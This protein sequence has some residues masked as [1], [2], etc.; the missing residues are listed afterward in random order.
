MKQPQFVV[1]DL[2]EEL[3]TFRNGLVDLETIKPMVDV[4]QI[5]QDLLETVLVGCNDW[6]QA[7]HITY[8]NCKKVMDRHV[9]RLYFESRVT[10]WCESLMVADTLRA[11]VNR[12]RMSEGGEFHYQFEKVERDGLVVLSLKWD[13]TARAA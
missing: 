9:D 4:R 3:Q 10:I 5:Q 7:L 1:F 8:D 12:H 2:R 13:K 6:T 11:K